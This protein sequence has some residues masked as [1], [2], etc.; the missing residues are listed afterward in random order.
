MTQ[1]W[2]SKAR[3]SGGVGLRRPAPKRALFTFVVSFLG[4]LALSGCHQFILANNDDFIM[5]IG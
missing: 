4:M 1:S 5:I 3:G 2:A